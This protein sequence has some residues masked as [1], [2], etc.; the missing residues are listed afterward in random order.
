MKMLKASKTTLGV[1]SAAVL[2]MGNALAERSEVSGD[3]SSTV[4]KRTVAMSPHNTGQS[5]S[6][7]ESTGSLKQNSGSNRVLDGA[8]VT[9]VGTA[10][11]TK[12]NG[13]STSWGA[14]TQP[15]GIAYLRASSEIKTTSGNDGK[16]LTTVSGKYEVVG[17]TGSLA[18][19]KGAG[20]FTVESTSPT[21]QTTHYSGW[22]DQGQ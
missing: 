10:D 22:L 21:T 1:I 5:F 6:I 8:Q 14:Y 16:P 9:S 7:T 18:S 13:V 17:G 12:G 3:I 2:M 4:T 19:L 11:V 20:E 15:G